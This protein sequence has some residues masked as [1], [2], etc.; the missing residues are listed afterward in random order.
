MKLSLPL[1]S[2]LLLSMMLTFA[3]G[4]GT[5]MSGPG[6]SRVFEP[7]SKSCVGTKDVRL[8]TPCTQEDCAFVCRHRD[9]LP[10]GCPGVECICLQNC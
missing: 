7:K 2:V 6:P 5:G 9:L 4:M 10:F 3:T 8:P 1:A